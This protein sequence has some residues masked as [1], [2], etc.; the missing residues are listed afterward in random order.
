MALRDVTTADLAILF[1]HQRE[2]EANRLAAFP[3]REYDAFMTHWR[4]NV[5]GNPRAIKQTIVDGDVV[6]GH[7]GCWEVGGERFV[8]Y[9]IGQKYW[10]RGL[11]TAALAEFI[12]QHATMRPL[13]AH[14]ARHNAGS[15]RVLEKCGFRQVGDAVTGD[16]GVDELLF[17][18]AQ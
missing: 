5:L 16:G 3:A 15:I 6:V 10:N 8:G 17:V 12:A 2:P 1:E 11:A 7:I 14:V 4:T 18:L 9:W 13:H